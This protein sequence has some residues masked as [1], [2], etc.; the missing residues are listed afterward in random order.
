MAPAWLVIPVDDA[1]ADTF[2]KVRMPCA[3][4]RHGQFHAQDILKGHLQA[5][6]QLVFQKE[7]RD[8]AGTRQ[9]ADTALPPVIRDG[10]VQEPLHHAR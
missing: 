8:R 10:A 1:G 2:P 7:Q 6:G 5:I 9:P 4:R 3:V